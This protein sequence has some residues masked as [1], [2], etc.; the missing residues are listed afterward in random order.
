MTDKQR[1]IINQ[2]LVEYFDDLDSSD[3]VEIN[4]DWHCKTYDGYEVHDMSNFNS[5]LGD[6]KPSEIANMVANGEYSDYDSW[7]VYDDYESLNTF[8]DLSDYITVSDIIDYIL[9]NEDD[10][11]FT[12]IEEILESAEKEEDEILIHLGD[13]T[14]TYSR[15]E[16]EE[17]WSNNDDLFR[18]KDGDIFEA[19]E[20][21]DHIGNV[22]EEEDA[23]ELWLVDLHNDAKEIG[24]NRKATILGY[25][26]WVF[27]NWEFENGIYMQWFYADNG[28]LLKLLYSE[29]PKGDGAFDWSSP[30]YISEVKFTPVNICFV[31]N[32]YR[33][34]A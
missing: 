29:P 24:N 22:D 15:K 23:V 16:F 4:N 20:V 3:L 25:E 9:E 17:L 6:F 27:G 33:N 21:L 8:D 12:E 30:K 19:H 5:T 10:M 2:K 13:T 32:A 31:I 28:M 34:R 18:T 1:E 26:G 14:E 7:F 11:G